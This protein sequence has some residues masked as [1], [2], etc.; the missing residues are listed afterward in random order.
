[1]NE[2]TLHLHVVTDM[3]LTQHL[4]RRPQK[5]QPNAR[6][7]ARRPRLAC[8]LL[9]RKALK[10]SRGMANRPKLAFNMSFA[11]SKSLDHSIG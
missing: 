5:L 4:A 8:V 6:A 11:S 3:Q 2:C 7:R 10:R 9:P 1:M